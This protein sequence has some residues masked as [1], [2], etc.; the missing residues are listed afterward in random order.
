[1]DRASVSGDRELLGGPRAVLEAVRAGRRTIHRLLV[2]RQ[3]PGEAVQAL[4]AAAQA[5]QIPI[6][7]CPR[8]ELDRRSRGQAHQGVLA[9]VGPFPYAEPDAMLTDLVTG[10]GAAFLL[11]LDG[12]QDP[13]NLGAILRTAEAAGVQ[14]VILPRDRAAAVSPAAA[15]ASAGASEHLLIAR[16]TNLA[17]FLRRLQEHGL[18]IIGTD[19][20]DGQELFRADLTGPMALVVGGEGRGLRALTRQRCDTLVHIPSVGRV[21]SLNASAAAAICL[22]EAV[23]QRALPGDPSRSRH[24]S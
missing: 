4:V 6:Q 17:G 11:I 16:V 24:D 5:R 8:E 19:V 1:M 14:G 20:A 21:A 22:F 23:R 7:A 10:P 2:A 13:Q 12:I 3:E 15:R 18:W 9:E